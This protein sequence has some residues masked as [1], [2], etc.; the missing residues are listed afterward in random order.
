VENS[1]S[2]PRPPTPTPSSL[3]TTNPKTE[4]IFFNMRQEFL[5]SP[6][7]Q[8]TW[9][10]DIVVILWKHFGFKQNTVVVLFF[11][12]GGGVWPG[13]AWKG[14]LFQT[15][16]VPFLGLEKETCIIKCQLPTT[17]LWERWGYF[18]DIFMISAEYIELLSEFICYSMMPLKSF[19]FLFSKEPLQI[20][21]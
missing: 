14:F 3:A 20:G 9:I 18:G 8:C 17:C 21:T 7:P 2:F 4:Q 11:F 1:Q 15:F 19:I 12:G 16:P 6:Q 13:T 10:L 5:S